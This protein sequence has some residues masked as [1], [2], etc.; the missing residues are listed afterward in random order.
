MTYARGLI[1]PGKLASGFGEPDQVVP[2]E[3]ENCPVCGTE[4]EPVEGAR[5]KVE[6]VAEGVEQPVE[7]R[8]YRRPLYQCP[9]CGWSGYT[10]LPLGVKEGFS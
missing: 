4:L 8:E 9:N 6:Q 2:L 1:I 7:I 3:L 10:P 5:E